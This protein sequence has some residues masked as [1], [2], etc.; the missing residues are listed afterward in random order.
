[1]GVYYHFKT[2]P[3]KLRQD[4]PKEVID[5]IDREVNR[6]SEVGFILDHKFF[7]LERWSIV[8]HKCS[9]CDPGPSFKINQSGSHELFIN[10]DINY[11]Y[12]EIEEFAKWIAPYVIG[13]KPKEFIGTVTCHDRVIPTTNVYIMRTP[14]PTWNFG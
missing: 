11:G 13:H 10:C 4:T 6:H 5:L 2:K 3:L 14:K 1:M 8:F 9:T 7:T 12:E